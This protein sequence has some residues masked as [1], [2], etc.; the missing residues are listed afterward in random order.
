M[1]QNLANIHPD[2]QIAEGVE[3]AAFATIHEDVVIGKGSKIGANTVIMNGARIGENVTIYPNSVI[4]GEPQDLK[5]KGEITTAEIGDNTVIR[6][7]VT[8]NRGTAAAGKTVVGKNCLLMAYTHVAHDCMLGN[9]IIMANGAQIAGEVQ[10]DDFAILGG[11]TLVHQFVKI[12]AHVMTQAGLL[13][14]KDVPPY[15]MAARYPASYTGINVVGLRRRGFTK[16]QINQIQDIYRILYNQGLNN[17]KALEKIIA[18]VDNTPEKALIVK[19][20]QSS[21]RG[22]VGV[23]GI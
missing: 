16:E 15:A 14:G 20:L 3:I 10:I 5:F 4:S 13:L 11:G 22:I 19:F 12:G 9:N 18:E 8:V 21:N 23:K 6:E 2:A 1:S 17:T 7:F